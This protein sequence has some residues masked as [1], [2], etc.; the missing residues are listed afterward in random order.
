MVEILHHKADTKKQ[1]SIEIF[2]KNQM[3]SLSKMV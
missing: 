3:F 2:K 1:Y